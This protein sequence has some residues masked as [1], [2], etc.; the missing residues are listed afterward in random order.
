MS[1]WVNPLRLNDP[2]HM[3]RD[4][5]TRQTVSSDDDKTPYGKRGQPRSSTGMLPTTTTSRP[6]WD[7]FA[8]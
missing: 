1:L 7:E 8:C 4:V 3:A 2:S 5:I 6:L